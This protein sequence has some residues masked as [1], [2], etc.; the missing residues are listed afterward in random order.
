MG[1]FCVGGA[2]NQEKPGAGIFEI[3]SRG[4]GECFWRSAFRLTSAAGMK[5]EEARV[6]KAMR[7]KKGTG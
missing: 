6:L 3:G 2:S 1:R 4:S 7:I 5:G